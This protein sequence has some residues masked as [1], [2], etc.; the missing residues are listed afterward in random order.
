MLI[1]HPGLVFACCST[2]HCWGGKESACQE[3]W[4]WSLGREDS[5]GVGNGNPLQSSCL[6]NLVDRGAWQATVHWVARV[7][8][9]WASLPQTSCSKHV[10]VSWL[11]VSHLDQMWWRWLPSMTW[12]LGP[13]LGGRDHRPGHLYVASLCGLSSSQRGR[14]PRTCPE[15]MFLTSECL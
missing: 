7:G 3:M 10:F 2:L 12:C 13:E 9:E 4:V 15:K 6:E 1:F 14:D 5:P 8:H 11:W